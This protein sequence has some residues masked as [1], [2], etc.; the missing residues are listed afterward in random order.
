MTASFPDKIKVEFTEDPNVK[1][2]TMHHIHLATPN[3][4]KIRDWYVKMFGAKQV[5]AASSSP[6]RFPADRSTRGRRTSLRRPAKAARSITSG[7]K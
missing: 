2:T 7:S 6:R 4:E 1:K 3:P 5:Y